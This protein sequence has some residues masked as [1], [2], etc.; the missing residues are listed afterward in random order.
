MF[1]L[2]MKFHCKQPSRLSEPLSSS[3]TCRNGLQTPAKKAGKNA[4][5]VAAINHSGWSQIATARGNGM[6]A[7]EETPETATTAPDSA[8][9]T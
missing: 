6:Y 8:E 3:E 1:F 5:D 2:E 4:S 7:D 9:P